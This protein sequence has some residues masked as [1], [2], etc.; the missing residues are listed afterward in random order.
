MYL[1]ILQLLLINNILSA[2]RRNVENQFLLVPYPQSVKAD[3]NTND[4][5]K[6]STALNFIE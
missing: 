1:L 2:S 6:I 5:I 3:F 4:A